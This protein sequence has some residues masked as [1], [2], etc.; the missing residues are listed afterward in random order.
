MRRWLVPILAAVLTS[1]VGIA[2][3]VATD[4]SSSVV[5]WV[6]V[7]VLTLAAGVVPAVMAPAASDGGVTH[8]DI[9]G[10]TVRGAVVQARDISA[11]MTFLSESSRPQSEQPERE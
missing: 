4:L 10:G 7:C 8:N 5:A 9:S 1:G 3:N 6:A 2:I 11:P